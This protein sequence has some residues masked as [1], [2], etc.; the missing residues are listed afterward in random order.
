MVP[1]G[2]RNSLARQILRAI[3]DRF[4]MSE[5]GYLRM[6]K[7]RHRWMVKHFEAVLATLPEEEIEEMVAVDLEEV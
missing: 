2:D 1:A 5:D 7:T 4:D 6:L 3:A